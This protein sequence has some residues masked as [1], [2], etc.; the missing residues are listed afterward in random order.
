VFV[1]GLDAHTKY[2]V[3]VVVN[4]QGE[5]VLTATRVPVGDGARLSA[6]LAPF[7]PLEVIVETCPTWPWVVDTLTPLGITVTLA[8]AKKL[9]AI[10]EATYKSDAIDGELLARMALAGLIPKVYAAPHAQRD[11]KVLLRHR[12]GLVRHRTMVANRVHAQLHAVGLVLE[13]G[14]L[15]TRAGRAWVRETAGPRLSV[16]ARALVRSHF[17]LLVGLSRLIAALDQRITIVA[18]GIPE[19]QLLQT[20]CGIG[21]HRALMLCAELLPIQRFRTPHHVVSYAGLAPIT[22]QSGQRPIRHG[23]IP[24]GANRWLRGTLVRAVVSHTTHAPDSPLTRYYTTMKARLGWPTARVATARKLAR[25]IHA[26]LAHQCP[27]TDTPSSPR[28]ELPRGHAASTA[29]V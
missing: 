1:A 3:V 9:R 17:R 10:A 15:L 25:G 2:L 16:E 4:R 22:K 5:R 13:R 11:W 7:R 20:I 29:I 23:P 6:V 8:H 24:G 21:A 19:A 28:G 14:R 26:M 12:E 27:W 18:A